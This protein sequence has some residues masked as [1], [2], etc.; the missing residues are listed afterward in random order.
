V[1]D[2]PKQAPD[3]LFLV[4]RYCSLLVRS[5][6]SAGQLLFSLPLLLLLTFCRSPSFLNFKVPYGTSLYFGTPKSSAFHSAFWVRIVAAGDVLVAYLAYVA[7]RSHSAEIRTLAVRGIGLYSFFH[8]SSF[9]YG[10][11]SEFPMPVS[12]VFFCVQ[13]LVVFALVFVWYGVILPC[14][15]QSLDFYNRR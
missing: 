1:N 2:L 9:L 15:G 13:S 5:A 7:A 3:C 8:F 12:M 14:R 11:S 6:L 4:Q 10:H